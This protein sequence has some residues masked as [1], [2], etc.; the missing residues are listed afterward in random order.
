MDGRFAVLADISDGYTPD[1]DAWI[2]VTA[3]IAQRVGI[4]D[5]SVWRHLCWLAENGWISWP[6]DQRRIHDPH[7]PKNWLKNRVVINWDHNIGGLTVEEWIYCYREW[8]QSLK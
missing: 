7:S 2:V 1:D 8:R 3:H 5:V 6:K 4:S